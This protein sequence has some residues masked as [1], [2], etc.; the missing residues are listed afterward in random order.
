MRAGLDAKGINI[1]ACGTRRHIPHQEREGVAAAFFA[2]ADRGAVI[3]FWG[4]FPRSGALAI[5]TAELGRDPN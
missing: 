5:A 4:N 1:F 3:Y 2:D